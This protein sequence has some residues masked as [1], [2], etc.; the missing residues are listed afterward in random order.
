MAVARAP[1]RI[2]HGARAPLIDRLLRWRSRPGIGRLAR[3]LLLVW[4]VDI[5][6]RV[7]IG[8][9]VVFWHRAQG[10]VMSPWTTLGDRVHVFHQ[11]TIGGADPELRHDNREDWEGVVIEEDAILCVGAKILAGPTLLTVGRGTV[12]GA[13]AVLLESTGEYEVWT[14]I[15]ARRVGTRRGYVPGEPGPRNKL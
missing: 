12:V 6:S 15:P 3:L 5:P 14:G 2:G 8:K 11:V 13:N 9:D 7:E 10:V 1:L 4:G